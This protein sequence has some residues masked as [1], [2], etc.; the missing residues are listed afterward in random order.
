MTH[1][2]KQTTAQPA[3]PDDAKKPHDLS[4]AEWAEIQ[5]ARA[6]LAAGRVY[7]HEPTLGWLRTW[8]A[9]HETDGPDQRVAPAV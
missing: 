8:G 4:E 2:P 3:V 7:T 5:E 9:D 6:D 1:D